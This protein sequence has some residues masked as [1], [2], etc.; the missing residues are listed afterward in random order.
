MTEITSVHLAKIIS[1]PY[2][3]RERIPM[4]KHYRIARYFNKRIEDA[5][6]S[7][8][9]KLNEG[10]ISEE[11]HV[12]SKLMDSIEHTI[13]QSGYHG[14]RFQAKIFQGRGRGSEESRTGAD[15]GGVLEINL[16]GYYVK[17]GFLAQAKI[18]KARGYKFSPY[19][20]F[21][22]QPQFDIKRNELERLVEQC[23]KMLRFTSDAY[24]FFYSKNGIAVA[25][26]IAIVAFGMNF[27]VFQPFSELIYH[28]PIGLF[29]EEYL[30]SFIGDLRIGEALPSMD[31]LELLCKEYDLRYVQYIGVQEEVTKEEWG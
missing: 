26:A 10:W 27:Q 2:K 21:P 1:V 20:G 8:L 3:V 15:I 17:K 7:V 28:K 23:K 30:K 6:S 9:R 4:L 22:P 13:N 18:V 11:D 19:F 14:I 24:V 31:Q 16:A 12:T 5:A 25:P 29:Y